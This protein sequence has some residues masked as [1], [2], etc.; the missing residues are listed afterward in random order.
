M[1]HGWRLDCRGSRCLCGLAVITGVFRK[2]GLLLLNL[3]LIGFFVAISIA[4]SRG[5]N[6]QCGCFG[7]S[8]STSNYLELFVRDGILLGIGLV[9]VWL[10]RTRRESL[11]PRE[12][13]LRQ[14]Q[15]IR[16]LPRG[17]AGPVPRRT[18][19]SSPPTATM[20][21]TKEACEAFRRFFDTDCDV[22]FVFN[23][24]AANSL[25]LASLCTS[26]NSIIT[27]EEAH[28]EKDECGAPEF[29]SH[30]AKILLARSP[31]GKLDP[32]D[33]ER[34]ITH[35]T[36]IHF[37]K[38]RAIS[39][40]NSTELGTVYRPE[41]I[42]T[43]TDL[44]KQ[45]RPL[46]ADGRRALLQCPRL[47]RLRAGRSHLAGRPRCSRAAAAPSSAWSS[48]RRSSSSIASSEKTLPSVASRPGSSAPRCASSPR[49][50]CACWPTKPGG[51]MP[52]TAIVSRASSQT[53]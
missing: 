35:R 48:P 1:R 2:G 40:S 39:I 22:Y 14:R 4:K 46:G 32:A 47:T 31:D 38:P 43:I 24:T 3:A 6:I 15:H 13:H 33:V 27:A 49:S 26:Y 17:L 34:L 19:A 41:E 44:A 20:R 51:N 52:R 37:P 18:P 8:D 23:G 11:T 29:F 7:G 42:K 45:P 5:L 21:S 28:C 36:D 50:G 12:L 9:L 16:H 25:A 53:S 30:G 10:S